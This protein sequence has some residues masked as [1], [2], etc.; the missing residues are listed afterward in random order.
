MD[1]ITSYTYTVYAIA[2]LASLMLV[3]LLIADIVGIRLK[4]IPGSTIPSDHN[5]FLFRASRVVTNTNETIAIYILAIVVCVF[6]N[7]SPQITAFISWAFVIARLCYA[8]C[9]YCNLKILRSVI[10][11][12]SLLA[13]IA[14]LVTGISTWF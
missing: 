1:I 8:L 7:A 4:H 3:Q 13:L 14:L 10:F 12:I 2:S 6:S 5:N 9:Y 11:G